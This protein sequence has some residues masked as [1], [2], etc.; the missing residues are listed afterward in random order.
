M[1]AKKLKNAP[2]IEAI[3]E[4]RW[5]LSKKPDGRQF[6]P[7]HKILLGI[8]YEKVKDDYPFHEQLLRQV[9]LQYSN[10]EV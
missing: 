5:E 3:F 9:H 6:D 1:T 8:I 4:L 2:L 10:K 7:H